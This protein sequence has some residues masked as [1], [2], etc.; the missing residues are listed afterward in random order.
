MGDFPKWLLALAALSL[1]P[2]LC[3]VF[4]LFGA[5]PFGTPQSGGAAAGLGLYVA[6]QLLW[7]A[8]AALFFVSLDRYRRGYYRSGIALVVTADALAALAFVLLAL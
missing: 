7:I 1:T 4:F 2:L 3:C 5:K 6:T 8:P